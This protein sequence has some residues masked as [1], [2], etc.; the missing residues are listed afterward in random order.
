MPSSSEVIASVAS[1]HALDKHGQ[2][3]FNTSSSNKL[4]N[5]IQDTINDPNTRAVSFEQP[6]GTPQVMMYNDKT[7]VYIRLSA[8]RDNGDLG[9]VFKKDPDYFDRKIEN[10]NAELTVSNS[11]ADTMKMVE[12]FGNN[13]N[14]RR[15]PNPNNPD[16]IATT[17]IENKIRSP[18]VQGLAASISDRQNQ[19]TA[20]A[21]AAETAAKDAAASQQH[22]A[23]VRK[24]VE[25]IAKTPEATAVQVGNEV[26]IEAKGAGRVNITTDANGAAELTFTP[27][28]GG[29]PRIETIAP[30]QVDKLGS[31]L[32]KFFEDIDL[33]GPAAALIAPTLVTAGAMIGGSSPA[34]AAELG[35]STIAQ[36]SVETYNQD[37]ADVGD[38]IN[39]FASDFAA[40]AA[41]E[42]VAAIRNGADATEVAAAVSKDVAVGAAGV[43]GCVALAGTVSPSL[44]SGIPGAI[45][46]G[47]A[48][49][50]GAVGA[51]TIVDKGID[52]VRGI[53]SDD[54]PAQDPVVVP[55]KSSGAEH[56]TSLNVTTNGQARE[57][58]VPTC[59]DPKN[60]TVISADGKEQSLIERLTN[61]Q[62]LN[63]QPIPPV[64][65][66][67][68]APPNTTAP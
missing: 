30:N 58:I 2:E 60:V 54:E 37:N 15:M 6:T 11:P 24:E 29:A 46:T 68:L 3:D 61:T 21:L 36:Y 42:T 8:S 27:E 45:L 16:A 47:G 20:A 44:A 53:F 5:I 33:K 59:V 14:V 9:T 26:E 13:A 34:E 38:Y 56:E 64:V 66:P 62:D 63:K 10:V 35:A 41:P 48:C 19:I 25:T 51:G 22:Q 50:A 18:E 49:I 39:S 12:D 55:L 43:A 31:K 28:D 67:P 52:F 1:G 7:N 65:A 23:E 17:T 57:D 32:A 40:Q 4:S